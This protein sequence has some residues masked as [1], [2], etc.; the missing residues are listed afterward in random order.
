[1]SKNT[2]PEGR[3]IP[4]PKVLTEEQVSSLI[5]QFHFM[6]KHEVKNMKLEVIENIGAMLARRSGIDHELHDL[7]SRVD[8]L[9]K[10]VEGFGIRL[11]FHEKGEPPAQP[12]HGARGAARDLTSES[13][14]APSR[15]APPSPPFQGKQIKRRG[16]PA[17][18]GRYEAYNAGKREKKTGGTP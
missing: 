8:M 13:I 2:P 14:P 1:M 16:R 11:T 18:K 15:P 17:G 4:D 5:A 7:S 10:A 6:L 3:D 12:R 9:A